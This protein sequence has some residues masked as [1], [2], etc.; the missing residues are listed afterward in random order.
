METPDVHSPHP[1]K[2][3]RGRKIEGL[4]R[5]LELAVAVTALITSVSSIILAISN[6]NSMDRLV[7]ANSIP[8][9]Q[10]GFSDITPEGARVLSLD[11]LNRGVGPAHERSLRVKVD[12]HYVR[13]TNELVAESLGPAAAEAQPFLKDIMKNQ[14]PTRFIPA[15]QAQLVFRMIRTSENAESWKLLEKAQSRWNVEFCYCSVFDECWYVRSK[16]TEPEKV[17]QCQRDPASEFMP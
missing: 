17:R 12:G 9:L 11:L 5:W 3:R 15:G 10:G 1:H 6:G 7:K 16:W 4:P 8:Y 2:P 14:V 13:S